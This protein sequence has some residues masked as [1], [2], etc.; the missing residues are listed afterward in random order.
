MAFS[1]FVHRD[2]PKDLL[3]GMIKVYYMVLPL[4]GKGGELGTLPFR[5]PWGNILV[6]GSELRLTS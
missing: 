6:D 1:W 2:D 3:T 4:R 5:E